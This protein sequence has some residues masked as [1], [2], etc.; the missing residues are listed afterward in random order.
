MEQNK[1]YPYGP[2]YEFTIPQNFFLL[3]DIIICIKYLSACITAGVDNHKL[4]VVLALS[5]LSN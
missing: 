3:Q 5:Q 2:K 1:T 4:K